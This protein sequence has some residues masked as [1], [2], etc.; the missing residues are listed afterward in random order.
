MFTVC[1]WD[2]KKKSWE[3]KHTPILLQCICCCNHHPF[4]WNDL[5]TLNGTCEV[6]NFKLYSYSYPRDLLLNVS[7]LVVVKTTAGRATVFSTLAMVQFPPFNLHPDR[8]HMAHLK[9]IIPLKWFNRHAWLWCVMPVKVLWLHFPLK[10]VYWGFRACLSAFI[11]CLKIALIVLQW[12]K[13][14]FISG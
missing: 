10:F 3:L 14:C 7:L 12:T 13:V 9:R 8:R 1:T 2:Q 5:A 6:G 11:R 4:L